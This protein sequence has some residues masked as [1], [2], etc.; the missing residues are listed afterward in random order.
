[1]TDDPVGW[2]PL[3]ATVR[4]A[5]AQRSRPHAR[6]VAACLDGWQ[7]RYDESVLAVGGV[8]GSVGTTTVSL[9]VASAAARMGPA[10]LIESASPHRSGL[11]AA[12]DAEL[13]TGRGGWTRG[14]RA[15]VSLIRRG[16]ASAFSSPPLPPE[17]DGMF[18]VLDAGDLLTDAPAGQAMAASGVSGWLF[19]IQPS[20]P[21]LRHLELVLDRCPAKHPALAIV[22]TPSGRWPRSLVSATQPRTRALIKSGRA[23]AFRHDRRLAIFGLTPDPLP[24]HIVASARRLLLLEG[25]VE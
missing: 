5:L 10:R 21:C 7:P 12:A 3:A 14:E 11:V 2:A 9:A 8:T 18:T 6:P 23:V 25:L 20:V 22:G 24:H 15:G 16:P 17:E 4:E 13:G 19:V 1:M